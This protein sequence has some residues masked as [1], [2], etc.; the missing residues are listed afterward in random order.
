MTTEKI[1][2]VIGDGDH[3]YAI[4]GSELGPCLTRGLSN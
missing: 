4:E 2:D 1:I 3:A